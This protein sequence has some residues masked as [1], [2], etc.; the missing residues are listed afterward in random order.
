M[1]KLILVISILV[2]FPLANCSGKNNSYKNNPYKE[3]AIPKAGEEIAIPNAGDVKTFLGIEFVYIPAGSFIMGNNYIH[4][5]AHKH[6][7]PKGF[8]I[9]KYEITQ[10]QFKAIMGKNPSHFKDDDLPVDSINWYDA[11]KFIKKLNS[12]GDGHFRLPT[13]AEWEY[14]CRAGTETVFYFGNDASLLGNYAWTTTNSDRHTHP[15]GE[16]LPNAWGLYDMLGNVGE[17]CEEW[18]DVNAYKRYAEGDFSPP[19][20][21]KWPQLRV[22]RG[23]AA[24]C[25][26]PDFTYP[27]FRYHSSYRDKCVPKFIFNLLINIYHNAGIRCVR[28]F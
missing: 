6:E 8:W 18:W 23:G 26:N 24:L 10:K 17:W 21:G 1:K 25:E 13:E 28:D 19:E 27:P 11:Q 9:S 22:Q 14:A 15:V 5:P 12:K 16:K 2:F 7:I 3:V 4:T 20:K